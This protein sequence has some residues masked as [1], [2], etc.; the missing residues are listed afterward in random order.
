MT[1]HTPHYQIE[2]RLD[3]AN[4]RSVASLFTEDWGPGAISFTTSLK[5]AGFERK[6]LLSSAT[7]T[8]HWDWDRG[9]LPAAPNNRERKDLVHFESAN[10]F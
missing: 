1:S 6:D 10:S 5:I 4:A 2:A 9:A 3:D 8:F 7:G